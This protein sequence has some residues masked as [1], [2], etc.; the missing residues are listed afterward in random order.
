MTQKNN[1]LLLFCRFSP[2]LHII[3]EDAGSVDYTFNGIRRPPIIYG[4]IV[5]IMKTE[6]FLVCAK[7]GFPLPRE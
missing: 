4:V 6:C 3:V 7:A 2:F 1:F 5:K